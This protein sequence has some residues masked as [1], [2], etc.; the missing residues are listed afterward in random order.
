MDGKSV[1][2]MR[3]LFKAYLNRPLQLPDYVLL[4]F[5]KRQKIRFMRDLP[6]DR[7]DEEKARY[8]V[9]P[10]FYRTVCDF[11]AGMTDKFVFDEYEK[12]Y[13]PGEQV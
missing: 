1:F 5:A 4:G 2:L 3:K 11:V 12:L 13:T 6:L 9:N 7:T 8:L 10:A